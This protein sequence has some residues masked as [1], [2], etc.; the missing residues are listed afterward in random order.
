MYR[1]LNGHKRCSRSYILCS[2]P[3]QIQSNESQK[4]DTCVDHS[5][6]LG[7]VS[8]DHDLRRG[9]VRQVREMVSLSV[10]ACITPRCH[11]PSG[12]KLWPPDEAEMKV[13]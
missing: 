10:L 2:I 12:V 1:V 13:E 8:A 6:N 7:A 5:K 11:S 3:R 9:G 4:T